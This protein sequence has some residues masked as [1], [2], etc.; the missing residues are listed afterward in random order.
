[1]FRRQPAPPRLT[2]DE[3]LEYQE[4]G[5]F[6]RHDDTIHLGAG[7]VIDVAGRFTNDRL[8]GTGAPMRAL[9]GGSVSLTAANLLLDTGSAIDVSGGARLDSTGRKLTAGKGGFKRG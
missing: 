2:E 8:D 4:I 9:D 5:E 1:M 7:A 6:A 3:R